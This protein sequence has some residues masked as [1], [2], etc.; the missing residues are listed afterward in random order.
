MRLARAVAFGLAA[1]LL[2]GC[3]ADAGGG[4]AGGAAPFPAKALATIASENGLSVE[5][6]TS[7]SQPP[8]R[9]EAAVEFTVRDA[10]GEPVDG[11]TVTGQPWM[12]DMG[13][14]ASTNPTVEA[15][16]GGVYR[17][18]RVELFM[19]GRWELRASL[20]GSA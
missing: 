16:G 6:R 3:A 5:V 13:H 1:P 19:P 4:G 11:L 17:F 20:T 9:G 7:P 12:P 14:G 10:Q 2:V 18:D 15:E 8:S